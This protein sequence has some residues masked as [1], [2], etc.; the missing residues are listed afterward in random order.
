MVRRAAAWGMPALTA[1]TLGLVLVAPRPACLDVPSMTDPVLIRVDGT[2]LADWD[3]SLP[4]RSLL[5]DAAA[6]SI[7]LPRTIE[8]TPS[9]QVAGVPGWYDPGL[10]GRRVMAA[11]HA[12]WGTR[13][14]LEERERGDAPPTQAVAA[15]A[16]TFVPS[17]PD[18]RPIAVSGRIVNGS[19]PDANFP[20]GARADLDPMSDAI[21]S[22]SGPLELDIGDVWRLDHD[23]LPAAARAA[24]ASDVLDNVVAPLATAALEAG[25]PVVLV[26]MLPSLAE[27]HAD[28]WRGAIAILG[29]R[30]GLLSSD[31]REG[32]ATGQRDVSLSTNATMPGTID[33][34]R[35]LGAFGLPTIP[36]REQPPVPDRRCLTATAGDEVPGSSLDR[37]LADA[38]GSHDVAATVLLALLTAAAVTVSRLTVKAR[39]APT[40]RLIGTV[41][42]ASALL[43]PLAATLE[44]LF[45]GPL[46]VRIALLVS[47]IAPGAGLVAWLTPRAALGVAGMTGSIVAILELA[48]HG[49]EVSSSILA[50]PLYRGIRSEGPDALL[51]ALVVAGFAVGAAWWTDARASRSRA[52]G[53]LVFGIAATVLLHLRGGVLLPGLLLLAAV[54]G[55]CVASRHPS[56]LARLVTLVAAPTAVAAFV[57][58]GDRFLPI[59]GR[60]EDLV[61]GRAAAQPRLWPLLALLAGV[62]L[63]VRLWLT[64][65]AGDALARASFGA[66][67][68]RSAEASLYALA[69]I[70]A[71][72]MAAG[73]YA[74]ALMILVALLVGRTR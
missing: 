25:R 18:A 48:R 64:Q 74:A 45:G 52:V 47:V 4:L 36:Q 67:A 31:R 26:S 29:T 1:V 70:A 12:A 11:A 20:T 13:A 33:V 19:K 63:L 23:R 69:P 40:L 46:G 50:A 7:L 8:E 35:L 43:L 56:R 57:L 6:A 73:T 58:A 14:D 59:A 62:L 5:A 30:R 10:G 24:F 17:T 49:R 21:S 34:S 65:R 16:G 3:R 15:T 37:D 28:R 2:T 72:T 71:V 66:P 61:L 55:V 9:V 42:A 60:F 44:G 27:Q 68:W 53:I 51:V 38:A 41:I 22:T 32:G 54:S 39:R